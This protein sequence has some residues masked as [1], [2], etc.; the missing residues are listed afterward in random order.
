MKFKEIEL[1]RIFQW[2]RTDFGADEIQAVR[3]TLKY[4]CEDKVYGIENLIDLL[5]LEGG[6]RISY[7]DYN[8]QLNETMPEPSASDVDVKS[9][10][11]HHHHRSEHGK[12]SPCK[13]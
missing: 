13:M 9:H 11:H 4:L 5:V 6:V 7:K 1:S 2:Y 8:W 10:R 12:K 3:W